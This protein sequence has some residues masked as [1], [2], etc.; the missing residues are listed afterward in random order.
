MIVFSTFDN[1]IKRKTMQTQKTI[2]QVKNDETVD[3]LLQKT[4]KVLEKSSQYLVG[5]RGVYWEIYEKFS[6]EKSTAIHVG[7]F[8]FKKMSE[9]YQGIDKRTGGDLMARKDEQTD[10]ERGA[11]VALKESLETLF[12]GIDTW[13]VNFFTGDK[14]PDVNSLRE[15]FSYAT[16]TQQST[17]VFK[18]GYLD[19]PRS[20][21]LDFSKKEVLRVSLWISKGEL[22]V[23]SDN[24]TS[25]K[26]FLEYSKKFK[27]FLK[28][29]VMNGPESLRERMQKKFLWLG[30]D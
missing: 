21:F 22:E 16:I 19:S 17:G 12:P 4:D 28:D 11:I 3:L 26:V 14:E 1:F 15:T 24:V 25:P 10:K 6:E 30:Q 2:H 9:I 8:C 20:I 13:L 7:R 23:E 18:L 5:Y 27:E 29:G